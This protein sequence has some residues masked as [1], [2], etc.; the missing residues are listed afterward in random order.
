MI[1]SDNKNHKVDV[2]LNPVDMWITITS[3]HRMSE[4]EWKSKIVKL[5]PVTYNNIVRYVS[6]ERRKLDDSN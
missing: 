2:E 3:F 6:E 1:V 4:T 5:S